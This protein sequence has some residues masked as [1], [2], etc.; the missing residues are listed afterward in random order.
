MAWQIS[1]SMSF[2][3]NGCEIS[4][5]AACFIAFWYEAILF[6]LR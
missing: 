4:T 3:D 5:D 2:D 6:E 1:I